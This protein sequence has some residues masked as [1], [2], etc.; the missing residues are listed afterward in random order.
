MRSA[1]RM[2]VYLQSCSASQHCKAYLWTASRRSCSG[3]ARP[4]ASDD[5]SGR[6]AR[7]SSSAAPPR[8]GCGGWRGASV[9]RRARHIPRFSLSNGACSCATHRPGPQSGPF[10]SSAWIRRV[11]VWCCGAVLSPAAP[12]TPFSKQSTPEQRST[13]CF[14]QSAQAQGAAGDATGTPSCGSR[15]RP[16]APQRALHSREPCTMRGA[17]CLSR[18]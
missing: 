12:A 1:Q 8:L 16:Q 11:S 17:R 9:L 3:S 15:S 14:P 4:A 5:H 10:H 7:G 2:E 13:S 6:R 18:Q